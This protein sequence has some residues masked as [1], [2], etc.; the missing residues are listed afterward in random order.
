MRAMVVSSPGEA[1]ALVLTD[2]PM[3]EL[4]EN[5]VRIKV[6]ACGVCFHDVVTRNGV[7]KRGIKMPVIPGHEISGIVESVGPAVRGFKPGDRVCTVQRRHIC[8]HCNYCR[9]GRETSCDE[10]EFLGD[11]G[12]NGGYAEYVCVE[13]DNV[14]HVPEGIPLD[15][16]SV[17]ACVIGT[18]LNAVRDVA[19][20]KPGDNV[21][22]TGSGGGLG[23]H[24][25]Q[26]ARASGAYTIGLTTTE[27]KAQLIRDAG[28]HEVVICDRGEDFSGAVKALTGG[29]G[30]DVVIDNVGSSLFQ[31]TR[32]SLAMGGRWIFVGQLTGEFVQLN[33]AQLFMRDISIRSVKS[34]SLAQLKDSL[35]MVELGQVRPIIT[36]RM[37]LEKA[38]EA[39]RLVE[40]GRSTGRIL[41]MPGL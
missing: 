40:S 12:L 22:V 6:E 9:S 19:A 17:V 29:E 7:L 30:A 25:V 18:E 39:H 16:A 20:V 32:K 37:P 36:D 10:R 24:G 5:D 38:A 26:L 8:G 33:P 35:R 4:R 31:P 2:V 11:W 14:A 1:E 27:S 13:E 34:T 41:L 28:A 15:E 23:I 21:L 3:P